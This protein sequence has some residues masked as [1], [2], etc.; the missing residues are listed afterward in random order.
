MKKTLPNI[1]VACDKF[2]GTLSAR[3]ANDIIIKALQSGGIKANFINAPM[4]DGGEGTSEII[5]ECIGAHAVSLS[6]NDAIMRP[7]QAQFYIN[8]LTHEAF[9]DSSAIIGLSLIDEK[10]RNPW[11]ST[12]YP[13]GVAV[14]QIFEQH[15]VT[16]LAIGIGGTATIDGGAGFMQGLGAEFRDIHNQELPQA[17]RADEIHKIAFYR[18]PEQKVNIIGLSDVKVP[19]T[20]SIDKPSSLLFAPQKGLRKIHLEML[21]ASLNH[22]RQVTNGSMTA[23]S[24][25]GGGLGYAIESVLGCECVSG[26]DY[27]IAKYRFEELSPALFITGEGS[28][29]NQTDQGKAVSALTKF[30]SERKIPILAIGGRVEHEQ[31]SDRI[32]DTSVYFPDLPLDS[33]IAEKRLAVTAQNATLLISNILAKG[34]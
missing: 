20:D 33:W 23:H 9:L 34:V 8:D 13:L 28:I 15:K 27:M 14:K 26:A 19:L 16:S 2:K 32:L 5:A 1:I 10:D 29:D 25:A 4:A 22:W 17:I 7:I 24:G 18:P 31:K 3:K 12:S 11:Q 6:A 21:A 30:C